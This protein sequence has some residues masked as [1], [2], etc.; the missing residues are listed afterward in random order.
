VT[1]RQTAHKNTAR[2]ADDVRSVDALLFSAVIDERFQSG[3]T[4]GRQTPTHSSQMKTFG[5]AMS[6]FTCS[7]DLLQKEQRGRSPFN[8]QMNFSIVFAPNIRAA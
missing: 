2:G 1:I 7:C 8:D 5:P 6:F 4:M 3:S